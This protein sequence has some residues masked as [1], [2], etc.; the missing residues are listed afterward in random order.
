MVVNENNEGEDFEFA[1][2]YYPENPLAGFQPQENLLDNLLWSTLSTLYDQI[3][4]FEKEIERILDVLRT[5]ANGN[6]D[7]AMNEG[8][9][10]YREM[11]GLRN[12]QA[13]LIDGLLVLNQLRVIYSFMNVELTLKSL[14]EQAYPRAKDKGLYKW[15]NA[16]NFFKQKDI[17][18]QKLT[19][20]IEVDQLR[21]LCNNFKHSQKLDTEIKNIPEFKNTDYI[22]N[23]PIELFLLRIFSGV[24]SFQKELIEAVKKELHEYDDARLKSIAHDLR[25]KMSQED[26]V[27]LIQNLKDE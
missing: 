2:E 16:I 18:I 11:T 17:E 20:Y 3:N 7:F 1:K 27:K 12:Q 8:W 21:R 6:A 19:G 14:I 4:K 23:R 9:Y 22:E 13:H 25:K 5:E 26:I 24:Q 10:I 15:E